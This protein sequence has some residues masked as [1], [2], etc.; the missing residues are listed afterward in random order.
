VYFIVKKEKVILF[1]VF[2]L[3]VALRLFLVFQTG[4]FSSDDAYY[5]VRITESLIEGKLI[6]HDVLSYGGRDVI[7][8]PAFNFILGFGFISELMYKILPLLLISALVFIVYLI[9]K[10]IIEDKKY[11]LLVTFMSGFI[12]IL[13]TGTLNKV[14][15]YSFLIPL[16]FLMIYSLMKIDKYLWLFIILSFVLPLVH[17]DAFLFVFV[18]LFYLLLVGAEEIKISKLKMEAIVLCIF[19]VFLMEFIIFK[20]AFLIDGLGIIWQGIPKGIL[21]NYFKD[22]SIFEII[23]SVGILPIFL[24]IGGVVLSFRENKEKLFLLN[25]LILT[26]L[27]FLWLKIIQPVVGLMFLGVSLSIVSVFSLD[28]FF[29]YMKKTKFFKFSNLIYV[30]LIGLVIVLM[31]IPSFV[32]GRDSIDNSF[33]DEEIQGL[34]WLRDNTLEFST[35]LADLDE[36]HLISGIAKRKN[37]MDTNFLLAPNT[38]DRFKHLSSLFSNVLSLEGAGFLL[39]RYHVDYVYLSHRTKVKYNIR[40]LNY[41]N[42]LRKVFGNENVEIFKVRE[43]C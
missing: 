23:Y 38:D 17:A 2:L 13:I 20:K 4:N 26:T 5:N 34:E 31:V 10:E 16:I 32:D 37:V 12:P 25:A 3:V 18:L 21:G 7:N 19:L 42:C 29:N 6:D 8:T 40:K 36:G 15:V 28:R 27:L 41:E 39:E 22:I 1:V 14:S 11:V 9:S 24:G 43:K 35:V 33:N 30:S